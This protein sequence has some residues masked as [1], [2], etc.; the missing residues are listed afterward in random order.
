M[1]INAKFVKQGTNFSNLR[2]QEQ[3]TEEEMVQEE[4]RAAPKAHS[5]HAPVVDHI[6]MR[7]KLSAHKT[8]KYAEDLLNS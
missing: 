4:V 6:R 7:K 1:A 5:K 2:H 8:S 3:V